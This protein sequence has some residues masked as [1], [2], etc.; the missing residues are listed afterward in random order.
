ME[1]V[2]I[3]I[4]LGIILGV[5]GSIFVKRAFKRKRGYQIHSFLENMKS[6]GELVVFKA[7]TKEIVTTADHWLG[8]AGKKY[9]TWLMSEMKMAM[10]F[11]FEISFWYDLKGPEFRVKDAG[12]GRFVI[13]MPECLYSI[14]IKDISFYD[15]QS[16]KLLDWLLPPLIGKAFSKDF[17]EEDKNKLKD[18]AKL[19]AASMAD[20]LIKQ[21]SSEIEKSARQTMEML[22]RSF[23]AKSVVLDFSKSQLLERGV[24]DVSDQ[25]A[26]GHRSAMAS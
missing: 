17:S 15:E 1:K 18:E 13:T 4:L 23:G 26:E 22:A 9:L 8:N 24:T 20:Q 2:L 6:V 14:S 16:A 10:I 12:E 19:Q 11:Q 3:T 7:Y 25:P 21:L 5:A